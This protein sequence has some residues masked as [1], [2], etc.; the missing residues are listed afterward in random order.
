MGIYV[1]TRI[2][3]PMDALWHHTQQPK[4]HECW[5][6]RFSEIDYLPRSSESEP[7]RFRY[8]TR[9]GLGLPIT[10]EG[11]SVGHRD[12]VDG[13][14]SSA[15][16]FSSA[17]P[18]SLI[19]QGGGY[20]K[21]IPTADGIR[22]LTWYDYQPRFGVVGYVIDRLLFRPLMGWATAWSFDRLRLWL[23]R[24]V[25]PATAFRQ[26]LTHG[27]ARMALVFIF[28]YQGLVPKLLAHHADE[29]AMLRD[30]GLSGHA[31]SL[32]LV[33]AGVAEMVFALALLF[34]W[35][36][37]WPAV[38]TLALMAMATVGV[39]VRS[40]AYLEA[41]FNP[42]SLNLAVAALALVDLLNLTDLPSASRCLRSAP[43][44]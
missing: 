6:L 35:R 16:R 10:G 41:A 32:A 15:L 20:W 36:S 3:V 44:S 31:V 26:A 17:D 39:G 33:L 24:G 9:I 28:A 5:D 42:V 40:P 11:E 30:A 12:L 14:R 2:R 4:L 13:S 23:E 21:Y 37:R 22:F 38:L 43:V 25:H 18:R 29:L 34:C 1:E 27:V 19:R 8:A 7:Q